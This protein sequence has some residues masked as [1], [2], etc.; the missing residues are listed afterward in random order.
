MIK[1][2][3]GTSDI[4][5]GPMIFGCWQAA[6]PGVNE[7][8]IIAA[9][10][11]AFDAGIIA[12]DTAE[13]YGNGHS[14]RILAKSFEGKR[15]G[16][17]IA[18]KVSAH[19]LKADKVIEACEGSLKNLNT[20]RIDLYQIHWPSGSWGSPIVPISE[21]LE[22]LLKLKEQGKIRAIGVSN[23]NAAQLAEA[24]AYTSID[25]IQ[26]PYSLLWRSGELETFPLARKH[27]LSII[28]YSPLAQGLLTGKFGPDTTL[29]KSDVR[30][31]NRLF[32]PEN[33]GR[34]Q[35]ALNVLRVIA[36][37]NNTSLGNLA[38]SW[39][40]Y[41]PD[42]FPIVGART[43]EQAKDNVKALEVVLSPFDLAEID[44]AGRT[45][46]D[47]LDDNPKMWA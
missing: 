22:A 1:R 44:A 8:D 3:L 39:L 41:Q 28:A 12:F 13:G 17:V 9:N 4:T 5:I 35:A 2:Q 27:H 45:V 11:A 7:D 34:V 25:T 6:W 33:F 46:T 36:E 31:S 15:D 47:H 16:I 38:L 42:V 32:Q 24:A 21:T 30:F 23:F 43:P 29:D 10:V 20:D 18:T 40:L 26:P 37:R 14:E 19:N